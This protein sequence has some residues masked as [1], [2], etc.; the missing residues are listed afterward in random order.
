[1]K[2]P[3]C[4]G[5]GPYHWVASLSRACR[6]TSRGLIRSTEMREVR[7]VL[8]RPTGP[9]PGPECKEFLGRLVPAS[10]GVNDRPDTAIPATA[11]A[12][13]RANDGSRLIACSRN[14]WQEAELPL[15]LQLHD[16]TLFKLLG[17][18]AKEKSVEDAV[19]KLYVEHLV[20][21]VCLHLLRTHS[22][23]PIPGEIHRGGLTLSQ[24]RR[25]T[26]HMEAK[27]ERGPTAAKSG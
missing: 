13:A 8:G 4:I 20:D 7:G 19:S 18:I 10:H 26:Q 11:Q 24:L 25:I 27:F 5:A 21:A 17:L 15:T 12:C 2:S 9:V 14:C 3:Y 1:M 6:I 23:F 22:T 16:P